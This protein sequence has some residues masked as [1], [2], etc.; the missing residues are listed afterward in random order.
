MVTWFAGL[1][2]LPRLF[3]YHADPDNKASSEIFKLMEKRLFILMTIGGVVTLLFGIAL[4][5]KNPSV[6]SA[7]WFHAKLLFIGVLFA[8]HAWC[9]V[10]VKRF[11]ADKN[12]KSPR[13]YKLVNEIPALP[14]IVI[15]VL[16]VV[17]AF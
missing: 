17:K 10:A 14:L 15:M 6:F 5:A 9:Y 16:A 3:M 11:R 12:T 4:I 7:G 1:F 13:F 8:F 2:Y